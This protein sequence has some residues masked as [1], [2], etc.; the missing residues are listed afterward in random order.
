ME[1]L[2]ERG[3]TP[4]FIAIHPEW[5]TRGYVFV[6][7]A[8]NKCYIVC[9]SAD[10]TNATARVIME[11]RDLADEI[12]F[13]VSEHEQDVQMAVCGQYLWTWELG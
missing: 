3:R 9:H 7:E 6:T 4:H 10:F 1:F 5:T 8:G 2:Q 12:D 13:P 11:G